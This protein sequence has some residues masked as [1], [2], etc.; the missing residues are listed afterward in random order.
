[1]GKNNLIMDKEFKLISEQKLLKVLEAYF[2]WKETSG[3]VKKLNGRGINIPESISESIV[4]Y[5]NSFSRDKKKG[6]HDAISLQ[7]KT[8]QIKATSAFNNELTSF[9]PKQ[10][11][12]DELHFARFNIEKDEVWLYEIPKKELDSTVLNKEKNETFLQQQEQGR[13]PRFSIVKVFIEK[14]QLKPYKKV[15]LHELL[16]NCHEKV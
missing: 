12:F 7:G 4:C 16:K 2:C 10:G 5:F 8:I 11:K 6:S 14:Y 13:R 1:M 3:K 15:N 9:S